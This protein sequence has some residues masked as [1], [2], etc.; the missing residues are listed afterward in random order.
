MA[1]SLRQEFSTKNG[2]KVYD[3]KGLEPDYKVDEKPNSTLLKVLLEQQIIFEYANMY[4]E[5]YD[6]IGNAKEF[7]LSDAEYKEFV[8]FAEEKWMEHETESQ[9]LLNKLEKSAKAEENYEVLAAKF[10]QMRQDII[11]EKEQSFNLYKETIKQRLEQEVVGR[12]YYMKGQVENRLAKD[13]DV[14]EAILLFKDKAR[15]EKLLTP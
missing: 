10:E 5:E 11:K 6:S 3:G 13:T 15:F 7:E 2:R 9:Q 1:D 14:K 12:Y 4:R 8:K